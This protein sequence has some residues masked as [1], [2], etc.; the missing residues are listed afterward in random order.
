LNEKN[1]D[2]EKLEEAF[3]F[4]K[5]NSSLKYNLKRITDISINMK[6]SIKIAIAGAT[7]Y[8]GLELVKILSNHPKAKI[9]YLCAQQ[10]IGK[11]IRTFDPAIKNK[12]LPKIS[13]VEKIN[14]NKINTIFT[15]LPNGEAQKI[16]NKIPYHIKLFDLSADFRLQNPKIYKKWY[17]I[18]HKA[19]NLIKKSTYAITEFSKNNLSKQKIVACPG[20]YPTSIQLPLIPL[21]YN[22]MINTKKIIIDSKSGYSGAGKKI[23][24]KFKFKNLFQ[25]ISAYGVG[26]HRHMSEIDQELSKIAKKEIKVF[27]TPHLIPTFRGILSTIYLETTKGNSA[28]KIY[29]FLKKYHKKNYFVKVAK[30]NSSIST[31]DIINSNFCKISVCKDRVSNKIIIISAIDNLIKGGS[32]QAVQNM[33]VSYNFNEK[34]GLL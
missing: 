7:G 13:K 29:K 1:T 6:D 33:N 23:K 2:I 5:D 3:S 26:S 31:G 25:S 21:V 14:W 32:G 12:K 11:K 17:G 30:F 18:N 27:F 9:I 16:A 20:C 8:I 28:L 34:L 4:L 10:S 15:A 24:K 19:K 22:K